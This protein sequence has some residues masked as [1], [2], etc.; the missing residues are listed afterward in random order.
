METREWFAT[1][2]WSVVIA[3]AD[4]DSPQA[5]EALQRLCQ[6]Y[7]PPIYTF[8]RRRGHG[9]DEAEDLTQEFFACF[10]ERDGFSSANAAKGKLRTL[11]LTA[12][13]RFL[14]NEWERART[15]KR[16]GG[17][18]P[19]SLDELASR[20]RARFEVA[21]HATP[22]KMFERRWAEALLETVLERL[23]GESERLGQLERFEFLKPALVSEKSY[24]AA[25]LA[26]R[27]G[28]A[29]SSAYS[30]VHRLRQ[31]YRELLRDE[32]AQTVSGPG[33]IEEEL[34][35]LLRVLSS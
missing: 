11:L 34:R 27:L 24:S 30:A 26:A 9:P 23:R 7:W 10:L 18:T 13:S 35:C 3:A 22:E 12:V 15:Q 1:T 29:E 20:E 4:G 8:I 31:R 33:E 28:V 14:I 19:V 2:H 25:E 21:E 17:R 32:I 16:G 6:R 5:T